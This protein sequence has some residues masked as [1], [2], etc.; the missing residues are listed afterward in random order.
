[1]FHMFKKS[2]QATQTQAG[3]TPAPNQFPKTT[4]EVLGNHDQIRVMTQDNNGNIYGYAAFRDGSAMKIRT[5]P[6][7]IIDGEPLHKVRFA[8]GTGGAISVLQQL[9]DVLKEGSHTVKRALFTFPH[10]PQRKAEFFG[11]FA[12]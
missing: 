11:D 2:A 1:M 6:E 8:A 5:S 4:I 7:E 9:D 3:E 10:L 12:L